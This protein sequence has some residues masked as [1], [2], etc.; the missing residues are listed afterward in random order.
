V[1]LQEA[2]RV[3]GATMEK[4]SE[5]LAQLYEAKGEP[6]DL[7]DNPAGLIKLANYNLIHGTLESGFWASSMLIELGNAVSGEE[8]IR[9]STPDIEEWAIELE[10]TI[11]RYI[12][13]VINGSD[14]T[15][16]K[17]LGYIRKLILDMED[18]LRSEYARLEYAIA[19]RFEDIDTLEEKV[20]ENKFLI[21][22][23]SRLGSKLT[24]LNRAKLVD[25]S[26][27]NSTIRL[28]LFQ[29]LHGVIEEC[30]DGMLSAI[31]KLEQMLWEFQKQSEASINVLA[32]ARHLRDHH[33][34]INYDPEPDEVM[35][36]GFGQISLELNLPC[37][38][39]LHTEANQSALTSI[40]HALKARPDHIELVQEE[41]SPVS[42]DSTDVEIDRKLDI[43]GPHLE[44]ISQQA[45]KEVS[46]R[47]YWERNLKSK[48]TSKA[49]ITWVLKSFREKESNKIAF[50]VISETVGPLSANVY[51]KDVLVASVND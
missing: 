9:R 42:V 6:L 17:T 29:R 34:H 7:T 5:S 25:L 1:N 26:Q 49:F 27:N 2:F 13:A 51:V 14:T 36:E 23:F 35:D 22:K 46:V 3:V 50:T 12:G 33:G 31:P 18:G 10:R 41:F 32:L 4:S 15:E 16:R 28:L 45:D 43:Y 47:E 11:S 30:R 19:T 48:C 20:K 8:G 21:G 37:S 39:D 40:I 38:A 44:F 24:D